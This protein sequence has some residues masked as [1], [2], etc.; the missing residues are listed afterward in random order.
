VIVT[1]ASAPPDCSDHRGQAA[2]ARCAAC[3]RFLCDLCFRFTL[4]ARPGCARCAYEASTRPQRRVS[5]AVAFLCVAGGATLWAVRRYDAWREHPFALVA[6]GLAAILVAALIAA[7]A[8]DRNAPEVAPRD[9]DDAPPSQELLPTP[10]SPYRAQAR[11]VLLAVSPRVSGKATAAVIGASLIASAVLVPWSMHL[12]RWL[13]AEVVLALWWLTLAT[14]VS[15]LLF[16]GFRLRDDLVYF[17]PWDRPAKVDG[18]P[19]PA[20]RFGSSRGCSPDG[21]S[22]TGDGCTGIDGEGCVAA[23][24]IVAVLGAALGVAWIVVELALPIVFV[25]MYAVLMRAIR[26][27]ARD[28]RG[29]AGDLGKSIGLA[30]LWATVYVVPVAALTWAV[31]AALAR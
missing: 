18:G 11:R 28:T 10:G 2:L 4:G 15:V 19:A 9:P 7:S 23:L 29:C 31:H 6:G 3:G 30:A 26:H 5:L 14:T 1:Q 21:C 13:E 20:G 24:V 8:R 27:A 25:A 17:A 22:T 16:R 12:P